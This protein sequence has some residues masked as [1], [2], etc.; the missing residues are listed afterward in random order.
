VQFIPA[1][2]FFL[3]CIDYSSMPNR[4]FIH[5]RTLGTMR[6]AAGMGKLCKSLPLLASYRQKYNGQFSMVITSL[7][8]SRMIEF[9]EVRRNCVFQGLQMQ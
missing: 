1:F 5:H 7:E 9:Y 8:S 3:V 2:P 6:A 4:L